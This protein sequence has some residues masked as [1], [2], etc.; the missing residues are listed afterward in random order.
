MNIIG[1]HQSINVN[2]TKQSA[3]LKNDQ[4]EVAVHKEE[5]SVSTSASAV[6]EQSEEEPKVTY[7]PD[8]KKIAAMQEETDRRLID[9]FKSTVKK[10]FLRQMGGF[11]GFV[12]RFK[13]GEV[14]ATEV[15]FDITPAAIEKAQQETSEDGYWGVEQTSDR[16][17]EFAKAL[18]G[19]NPEKADMLLDAVKAGYEAAE[20]I[21]GGELPELSQKTLDVTI[22]KF[23]AWRDGIEY[24][25]EEKA[26]VE[27]VVVDP[28]VVAP[29]EVVPE[30]N[31]PSIVEVMLAAQEE[32]AESNEVEETN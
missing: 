23:E 18:S 7:Q 5:L 14:E 28:E 2:Y 29:V 30:E 12:E 31:E 27:N 19:D 8:M 22:K 1:S 3:H 4:A 32:S 10:G 15:E 24:V 25:P 6:Y 17:L 11:R 21:W 26:D 13:A 20:E 9:L 16:L